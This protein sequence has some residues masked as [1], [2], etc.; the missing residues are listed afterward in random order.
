MSFADNPYRSPEL[1]VAQLAG[2]DERTD[3]IRKTYL[4]LGGAIF[5]FAAIEAVLLNI[6]G[7]GQKVLG[8]LSAVPYSWLIVLGAFMLV[9]YLAESWA[10]S[11]VSQGTQ[12]LGLSLYVVAEAAIFFPLLFIANTFDPKIIPT[13]GIATLTIFGGLTAIVFF[14]RADFSFLRTALWLGGFVAM[15]LIVASIFLGFSLGLLFS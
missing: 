15:G 10:R 1:T 11:T 7:L 3:F 4:H 14:T 5:G 2:V 12:Y 8:G 9:S 6:P 13:A